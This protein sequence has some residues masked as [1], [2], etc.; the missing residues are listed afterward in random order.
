MSATTNVTA[1]MLWTGSDTASTGRS[2]VDA[3]DHLALHCG[4]VGGQF[5]LG[6]GKRDD[7]EHHLLHR[8]GERERCLPRV[9]GLD[10]RPVVATHVHP[11]I[12]GEAMGDGVVD[13]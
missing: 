6:G 10:D 3:T 9:A 5:V 2:G 7:V 1:L 11:R 12:R 4:L 13:R 8:A